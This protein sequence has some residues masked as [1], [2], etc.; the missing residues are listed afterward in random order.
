MQV[1]ELKEKLHSLMENSS[2]E[3]LEYMYSLLEGPDYSDDFKT[4][5]GQE[6][7]AYQEDETGNAREEIDRMIKKLLNN[8]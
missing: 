8:R 4:K 2:E 1:N 5:P 3:T 6:Y 7:E